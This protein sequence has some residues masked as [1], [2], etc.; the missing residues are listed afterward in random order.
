MFLSEAIV[1]AVM[2]G[3]EVDHEIFSGFKGGRA[4]FQHPQKVHPALTTRK[5]LPEVMQIRICVLQLLVSDMCR[6]ISS[7][8]MQQS[9]PVVP[10]FLASHALFIEFRRDELGYGG[11]VEERT[12][13][14]L[15]GT[16]A[17]EEKDGAGEEKEQRGSVDLGTEHLPISHYLWRT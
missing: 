2:Q 9:P 15:G 3:A 6:E 8:G 11:G 10:Q 4:V 16:S 1:D 5:E 17:K 12:S 13:G 7:C 14:G